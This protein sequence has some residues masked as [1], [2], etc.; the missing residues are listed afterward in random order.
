[1]QVVLA[2]LAKDPTAVKHVMWRPMIQFIRA[3]ESEKR[4]YDRCAEIVYGVA[5]LGLPG[6]LATTIKGLGPV[7]KGRSG[8]R[9]LRKAQWLLSEA[10]HAGAA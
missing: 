4:S 8:A 6:L 1:M 10:M 3:T 9:I 5:R 2:A 7:T